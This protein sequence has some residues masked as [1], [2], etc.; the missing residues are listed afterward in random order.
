[1]TLSVSVI[2]PA[3]DEEEAI[4]R[5]LGDL[6]KPGQ[7]QDGVVFDIVVVDNGCTDR[8]SVRAEQ[9]G[10]RVI[11][12]PRRGY[13][14]ACLAGLA[15][16]DSPDIILFLDGDYSDYPEE[17]AAVIAPIR[18]Q[19]AD[20][21]IGSRVLGERESGALLPQARAGNVLATTLIRLLYGVRYTDLGPFRAIRYSSLQQLQMSDR[22]YGWT[23][24]MQ[25]KAARQ[26]LRIAEVPVRYRKRIGQSKISG[27]LIGTV[28]A[29]HKILWTIFRHARSRAAQ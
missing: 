3:L 24:E 7:V 23:V 4:V 17:A 28:R 13:G 21:V 18:Q 26:G 29:G 15:A 12:E 11:H 25:V 1:M 9:M 16:V 27:T 10:A 6:P 20:L 8:T 2:I 19:R 14:Q 5:V 22:D